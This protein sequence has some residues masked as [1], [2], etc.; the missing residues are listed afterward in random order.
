MINTPNPDSN[1]TSATFHFD[2]SPYIVL[3][4]FSGPSP[5]AMT[6]VVLSTIGGILGFVEAAY[7]VIFGR[8][9]VAI[10][11]GEYS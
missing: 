5:W 3:Q 9:I 10:I 2:I 4:D 6:A 7:A 1:V 8:T 11:M